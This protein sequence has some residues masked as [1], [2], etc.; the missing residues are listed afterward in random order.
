MAENKPNEIPKFDLAEQIMAQHRKNSAIRRKGPGQKN[1]IP[2]NQQARSLNYTAMPPI[3]SQED[4]II[5][6]I[7]ARDIKKFCALNV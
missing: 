7:V 3:P 4:T 5:A 6:D 1:E 2:N